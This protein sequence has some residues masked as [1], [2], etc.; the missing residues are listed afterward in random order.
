MLIYKTF[1]KRMLDLI[2]AFIASAFL[3][4]IFIFISLAII[5]EDGRPVIF[6]QRRVGKNG[7]SFIIYKFRS[8]IKN[9]EEL[10]SAL[11]RGLLITRTGK[12]IRRI[13]LDELP[14]LINVLK[15]EMSIVGP[16]AALQSQTYLNDLRK[17]M[18]I[19]NLKPGLTG[20]AQINAYDG[21]PEDEKVRW[22]S[23]YAK[24]ITLWNDIKIIIKTF[25]Y[26]LKPPPVY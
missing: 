24:N 6:K 12:I 9:S 11:A 3:A 23:L 20:L 5:L 1:G 10:P 14:Q 16:R 26:L 7:K 18:G 8:M 17:S 22:D 13:S 4:P 25:L 21:M 15:G 2:L 19:D